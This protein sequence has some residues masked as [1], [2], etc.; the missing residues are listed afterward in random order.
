MIQT[1]QPPESSA[2]TR[3]RVRGEK[4]FGASGGA[5]CPRRS[6][7]AADRLSEAICIGASLDL[8]PF[9]RTTYNN[10]DP[11]KNKKICQ[12]ENESKGSACACYKKH[13]SV[14]TA[15]I[16]SRS[17]LKSNM[18]EL[19]ATLTDSRFMPDFFNKTRLLREWHPPIQAQGRFLVLSQIVTYR[20]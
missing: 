6:R 5:N 13:K 8:K 11:D 16:K 3:A 18:S 7:S 12:N 17:Q 1:F 14:R 20:E 4:S 19:T 9:L 15:D 2:W 10:L